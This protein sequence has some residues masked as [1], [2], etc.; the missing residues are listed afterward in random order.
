MN[1][2]PVILDCDPGV[3]DAGGVDGPTGAAWSD[4]ETC[5]DDPT[6]SSEGD[7]AAAGGFA[8][9]AAGEGQ[10]ADVGLDLVDPDALEVEQAQGIQ[11]ASAR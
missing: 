5:A 1:P 8:V 11:L 4:R 2:I 3:D 10:P 9:Q 7:Q 6:V